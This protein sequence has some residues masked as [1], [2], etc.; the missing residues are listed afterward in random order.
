MPRS[1][2]WRRG[3]ASSI[4]SVMGWPA[5]WRS[6]AHELDTD[7][8]SRTTG[9][10]AAIALLMLAGLRASSCG[11]LLERDIDLTHD[12]LTVRQDKTD[13]GAREIDML[14]LL[15]AILAAYKAQ[16]TREGLPTGPKDPLLS[17]ATGKPRDRHNIRQRVLAPVIT[18]AEELLAEHDGR[19]LP[20]GITPHK[21][22][23][24]FASILVAIDKDPAYVMH[25]LGHTDPAFTLRVYTHIM[26]HTPQEREALTALVEGHGWTP[27]EEPQPRRRGSRDSHP[28]RTGIADAMDTKRILPELFM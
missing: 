10:Q 13:A 4:A 17:T 27:G 16:K 1:H 7:A 23:H 28:D 5:S 19:P 14:P 21:L 22:R 25:Q 12:R 24:T 26:R 3:C 18:K 2:R 9:R 15:R 20:Q 6:C 8:T 11:A